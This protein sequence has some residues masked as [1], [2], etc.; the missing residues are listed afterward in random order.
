MKYVLIF[1]GLTVFV[2]LLRRLRRRS[3]SLD[4]TTPIPA[5]LTLRFDTPEAALRSIEDA[6]RRKNV[7][8]ILACRDFHLEAKFVVR[9][10]SETHPDYAKML[11]MNAGLC[12]THFLSLLEEEGIPEWNGVGVKVTGKESLPDGMFVM[13]EELTLP[14]GSKLPQQSFVG[15][16]KDGTYKVLMPYT[17]KMRAAWMSKPAA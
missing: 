12:K 10:L 2:I 3:S 7:R 14:D 6:Y 5:D 8:A 15:K 9:K 11:E 4:L 16:S 13:S 17:D 1:F